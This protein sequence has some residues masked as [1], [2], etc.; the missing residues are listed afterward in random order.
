MGG[1]PE[2][3]GGDLEDNRGKEMELDDDV[4]EEDN[5]G[6]D[7]VINDISDTDSDELYRGN[8]EEEE[9]DEGEDDEE[10]EEEE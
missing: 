5:D 6:E 9:D 1:W 8:G 3:G 2:G 7:F 4:T 10:E